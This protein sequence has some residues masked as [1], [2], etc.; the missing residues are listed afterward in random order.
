MVVSALD[1]MA[2]M[3][4]NDVVFQHFLPFQVIWQKFKVTE[5]AS[6]DIEVCRNTWKFKKHPIEIGCF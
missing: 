5:Y 3:V 6:T 2:G 1:Q 4:A